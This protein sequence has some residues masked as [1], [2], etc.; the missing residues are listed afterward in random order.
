MIE[1]A[2]AFLKPDRRSRVVEPP[3]G[4]DWRWLAETLNICKDSNPPWEELSWSQSLFRFLRGVALAHTG[5]W[6]HARANIALGLKVAMDEWPTSNDL[7]QWDHMALKAYFELCRRARRAEDVAEVVRYAGN[8]TQL[9]LNQ[10]M[11][12][13]MTEAESELRSDFYTALNEISDPSKWFQEQY[14]IACRDGPVSNVLKR[15]A[16]VLLAALLSDPSRSDDAF[17]LWQTITHTYESVPVP[18]VMASILATHLA[19]RGDIGGA[20]LVFRSIHKDAKITHPV[21]SHELAFYAKHAYMEDAQRTWTLITSQFSPSRRDRL[22]LATAY[23]MTGNHDNT[24]EALQSLFGQGIADDLAGIT[25]LQRA[26]IAANDAEGARKYLDRAEAVAQ[27]SGVAVPQ[28]LY[29]A[30]LTLYSRKADV[31]GAIDMFVRMEDRT[32]KAYTSVIQ[33]FTNSGDNAGARA[34]FDDMLKMGITADAI[35][36]SA[37]LN[38]SIEAG[39]W[40][41]AARQCEK[42]PTRLIRDKGL[43]TT[44]LKAFVLATAPLDR[45]LSIFNSIPAPAPAHAWALVIQSAADNRDLVK[46]RQLFQNM[47]DLA[48]D[49][50]R[51]H[52]PNVYVM[53]ILLAAYLRAGDRSSARAV[54]DTMISREV[55]PTSVT[56]GIITASFANAPGDNSMEQAHNFASSVYEN[57]IASELPRARGTAAE[58]V[59]GPL[60]VAAGRQG[61]ISRARGYYDLIYSESR[62]SITLT[63]KMM[64]AYRQAGNIKMV[65]RLWA[66]LFKDTKRALPRLDPGCENRGLEHSTSRNNALC[67]PLSITIKA[68]ATA[69]L[70]HRL[71]DLWVKVRAAGFGFDAQNY[72]HYAV[73]LAQTGDVE[74]AFHI[75]DRVLIP[76]YEEV[77]DRYYKAMRPSERLSAVDL[78]STPSSLDAEL[79]AMGDWDAPAPKTSRVLRVP[80][81]TA[82]DDE[83]VPEHYTS[84]DVAEIPAR[85]DNR[86][87][88]LSPRPAPPMPEPKEDEVPLIDLSILRYWR[89]S[90]LLWRPSTA[91]ISTLDQAYSQIEDQQAYRSWVGL[92]SGDETEAEA[93]PDS[94][95]SAVRLP[96]FDNTTVKNDDGST[97]R[98][99]PKVMLARIN[100]KYT[101]ATALVM[102]HRRKK[103]QRLKKEQ[104]NRILS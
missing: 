17:S 35:A 29:A 56:Y 61:D 45:V 80:R 9:V 16:Q 86:R 39:E 81:H 92:T 68:F 72:N 62:T 18:S 47:E 59:F 83:P 75:V 69:G 73:A 21:L 100:R 22:S 74:G 38:A 23:A 95:A 26:C 37:V 7:P 64:D 52:E 8:R 70:H 12:G 19:E 11:P 49:D 5:Q 10:V 53:S 89:P 28:N 27:A 32:I 99:S 6:E 84:D 90:D 97:K 2:E 66:R 48:K 14:E 4:E 82:D 103:A 96:S 46:A 57:V 24:M 71:K 15:V 3:N 20:R 77:R 33:A 30:L 87:Y 88:I 34:F 98:L 1:V 13:H 102:F 85:P 94:D 101:R 44:V 78:E 36:W 40:L 25:I 60:L 104:K 41:E 67:V 58:N 54:Y 76:R 93:E 79:E 63:A 55:L 43:A 91:T 65:Y 50:E 51:A 42:I 31:H